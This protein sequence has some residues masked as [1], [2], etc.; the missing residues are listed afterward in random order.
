VIRLG[1]D[2]DSRVLNDAAVRE[3]HR[4]LFGIPDDRFVVGWIGRMTAIKRVPDVL[5]SFKRLLD[6]GV[7]ATLCLVGDGP[8]RDEAEQQAKDLGIARH[9]LSVGY[10][11][12][13]SPYYA[14]FDALVLP[15]ANEGTPVVAIEALAAQR[16]VV[17]TRVG[18]VP[19]VVT[20][21]EDGFLVEVGDI[22][23]IAAALARLARDP[24]L[25]RRMG[26]SGREHVLPRYRVER[27][28]DDVDALYRELLTQQG[29]RLPPSS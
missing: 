3:E 23:G 17:A 20:E 27:L 24:E 21:G 7:D 4:R 13:V 25:R 22:D 6:L 5:T 15:S 28:V 18:G 14:L 9:V 1:I 11:R 2:L 10:Q 12:D 26:E 16:P 29:L 19:D 8:D